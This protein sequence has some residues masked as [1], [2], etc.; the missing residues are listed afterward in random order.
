MMNLSNVEFASIIGRRL[1]VFKITETT[2]IL[3]FYLLVLSC[4]LYKKMKEDLDGHEYACRICFEP[5]VRADFIAPCACAGTSKWVM[6]NS[7]LLIYL[8]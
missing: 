4:K 5:G 1:S 7:Y 3:V 6:R 2:D 8:A